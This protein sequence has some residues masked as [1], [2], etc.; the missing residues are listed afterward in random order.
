MLAV[1]D[2]LP[3]ALAFSS[4]AP[5]GFIGTPKSDYTWRSGPGRSISDR[6]H[7]IKGSEWDPWEWTLMRNGRCR[8]V[9][10]RDRL[11]GRGG[12]ADAE[13]GSSG[14]VAVPSSDVNK[15]FYWE[16]QKQMLEDTPRMNAYHSAIMQNKKCFRDRVVLD[17][18][19]GTGVLAMWAAMAGAKKV[20][21]VEATPMARKARAL[22]S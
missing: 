22:V 11:M 19:S 1:G 17:M 3:L 5:Y 2:L 8:L 13:G 7:R 20:Y 10:V 14:S 18:G 15:E 9:A 12:G 4:G 21:A 6:Y 16:N